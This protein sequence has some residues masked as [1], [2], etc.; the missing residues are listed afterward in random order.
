[1][2]ARHLLSPNN[3]L[4][5]HPIVRWISRKSPWVAIL[6][7]D[8]FAW[9]CTILTLTFFGPPDFREIVPF[10][11]GTSC[12]VA[13]VFRVLQTTKET[14]GSEFEWIS[15]F[16]LL[17]FSFFAALVAFSSSDFS[18][19]FLTHF[20]TC[21]LITR[22]IT[23]FYGMRF[24]PSWV[25]QTQPSNVIE[26][27]LTLETSCDDWNHSWCPST[28]GV[29]KIVVEKWRKLS[30]GLLRVLLES[31]NCQPTRSTNWC[32]VQVW[33]YVICR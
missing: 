11:G 12:L 26:A 25:V 4:S 8:A 21:F 3:F 7:S 19:T 14:V 27:T 9:L 17:L 23:S 2:T 15:L 29:E 30:C 5:E 22:R 33:W 24:M 28:N 16:K 18:P 31:F 20:G 10:W 32:W 13:T 1:M 6:S